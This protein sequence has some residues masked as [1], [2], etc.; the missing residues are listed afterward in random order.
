M[1]ELTL[2]SLSVA[3]IPTLLS[4]PA[5]A[6]AAPLVIFI[7]GYGGVKEAALGLGYRLAARGIACVS[8]DPLGHGERRN[9]LLDRAFDPE[10]GGI[11]PPE[12]GL[13]T[14]FNFLR[15]I[16]QCSADAK[17]LLTAFAGDPRLDVTR[18]GVTGHS[19]GAYATF[20]ALADIPA[21][22]AAVPMMGVPGFAER[23]Q[24][25]LDET[26]WSNPDWGAALER[27]AGET[28]ERMARVRQ[29]DPGPRLVDL[30]PRPLLLMNGD[31]DSDQPK[32]YTLRWLRALRP[33]YAAHPERLGWN[34]YPLGH[35][36]ADRM[37]DDA[38]DWFAR[39]L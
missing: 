25:I 10:L 16:E 6:T 28:A 4:A 5:G 21:L 37:L 9:A 7:P 31:F 20:L 35:V 24:D 11:Y 29:V 2:E 22:K 18:A 36:M 12:T 13:D 27:L 8:F 14:W 34:V 19:Q 17:Q 30:P 1:P 38:A 3:G 23:T 33:R 15:V 26:A 32:G 39:W